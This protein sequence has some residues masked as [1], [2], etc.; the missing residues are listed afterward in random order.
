MN[1]TDYDDFDAHCVHCGAG[2]SFEVGPGPM[3]CWNCGKNWEH[4]DEQLVEREAENERQS[5]RDERDMLRNREKVKLLQGLKV[6]HPT[7]AALL[8]EIMDD[9]CFFEA[10]AVREGRPSLLDDL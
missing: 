2:I 4:T 6:L 1:T 5:I 8:D 3:D 9:V 7:K 10:A